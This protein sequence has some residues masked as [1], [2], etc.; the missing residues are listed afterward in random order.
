MARMDACTTKRHDSWKNMAEIVMNSMK[1]KSKRIRFNRNTP[2][3]VWDFGM[4]WEAD[5]YSRAS[6]KDRRPDLE[7]LTGDTMDISE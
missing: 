2:K 3:G 6:G 4:V 7:R 1:V 5:I